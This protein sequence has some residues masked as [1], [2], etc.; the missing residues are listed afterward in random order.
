MLSLLLNPLV[1]SL[2]L[3][4]LALLLWRFAR[5]AR[6]LVVIAFGWL[7]L[8]STALVA[9]GLMGTLEDHYKPRA[10][11][12]L[13]SA[14]AIV[15]LGGA[16]RGDAHF[17]SMGD[18]NEQAD[19]LTHG[20]QLYRAGKA[21]LLLL[22][23]GG[24][25]SCRAESEIMYEHLELMGIPESAMLRERESRTTQENAVYSS[26]LLKGKGV[27]SIL[28]VTS[29]YHMRRAVP[30]F[31]RQGLAVVPAPTD[32][33]RL[34]DEPMLPPWLP[35]AEDLVRTTRAIKEHVGY[36]VYRSRGWL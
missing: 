13:P 24:C 22:S 19:R 28:L 10:L 4:L 29:A 1:Q 2:L 12:R 14:D 11:S 27:R 15:I 33:Q 30:L 9:D 6:S 7:Y 3:L 32:F 26:I 25:D 16:T 36:W 31:E 5:L 18:L 8:C 21:P 23:G 20:L 17:G 34:V 35:G